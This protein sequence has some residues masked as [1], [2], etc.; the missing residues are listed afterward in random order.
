MYLNIHVD[1]K[2]YY[3]GLHSALGLGVF[4]TEPAGRLVLCQSTDQAVVNNEEMNTRAAV[5][6][7]S[8][9]SHSPAGCSQNICM[10]GCLLL[11]FVHSVSFSAFGG[12]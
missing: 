8:P 1:A 10:D 12:Y 9:L 4:L 2:F 7:T 3:S 6:V 11:A 5:C